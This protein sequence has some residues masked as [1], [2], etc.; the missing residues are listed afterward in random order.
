MKMSLGVRPR[1]GAWGKGSRRARA[2]AAACLAALG[3]SVSLPQQ[4][5]AYPCAD[6][7][8]SAAPQRELY[9][10]SS[11]E[12]AVPETLR[13]STEPPRK[14]KRGSMRTLTVFVLAVAGVL[15]IPIGRNGL[16]QGGDPFGRDPEREIS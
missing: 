14:K 8:A 6:A 12:C 16:P 10:I 3:L 11:D 5:A 15:L 7:P 4:A 13:R 9:G 2:A 1:R